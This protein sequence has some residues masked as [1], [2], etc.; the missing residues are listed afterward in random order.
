MMEVFH[1]KKEPG[2]V[3]NEIP[4]NTSLNP[5]FSVTNDLDTNNPFESEAAYSGDSVD[6]HVTI[7]QANAYLAEKEIMQ[8]FDNQ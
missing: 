1:L 7:E 6:E 8:V 3:N 5:V 2:K 4:L